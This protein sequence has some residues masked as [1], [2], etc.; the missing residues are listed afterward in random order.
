MKI[1]IFIQKNGTIRNFLTK[2]SFTDAKNRNIVIQQKKVNF[3]YL[4]KQTV[5]I[6]LTN[7]NSFTFIRGAYG[8]SHKKEFKF[9]DTSM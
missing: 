6:Q 1:I 4:I 9:L 7:H 2:P 3:L 8:T 5:Y